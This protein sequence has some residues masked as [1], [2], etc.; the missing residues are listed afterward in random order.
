MSLN[1]RR[2][3][4]SGVTTRWRSRRCRAAQKRRAAS[5]WPGPGGRRWCRR[6]PPPRPAVGVGGDDALEAGPHPG[7]EGGVGLRAGDDVPAL[8]RH[9]P[10]RDR[11]PLG[12]F[13]RNRPASHSPRCTSR[14]SAS[15]LGSRPRRAASGRGRLRRAAQAGH[16][17]GVD[18][19]VGQPLP[20]P[21]GLRP[22]LGRQRRVAVPVDEVVV[23]AL[24]HGLG[25]A[26]AHQEDL[27]RARRSLESVLTELSGRRHGSERRPPPVRRRPVRAGACRGRRCAARWSRHRGR[28]GTA[29]TRAPRGGGCPW[30]RPAGSPCRSRS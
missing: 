11:V 22:S 4:R 2:I 15:T 29:R 24:D 12:V 7:V 21:L 10:H 19:L 20:H 23:P 16:V 30:P 17:D 1:R 3:Q 27:G 5:R 25:L 13:C 28:P 9:H 6:G 26:M 18:A 8:L 14:R